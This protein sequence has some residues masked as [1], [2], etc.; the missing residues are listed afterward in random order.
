M[1]YHVVV[2]L[3]LALDGDA[4]LLEQLRRAL[5]LL[6]GL[7]RVFRRGNVRLRHLN[8]SRIK[9]RAR[10]TTPDRKPKLNLLGRRLAAEG[11]FFLPGKLAE[12]CFARGVGFSF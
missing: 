12:L 1:R 10:K 9:Q 3:E 2:G 7:E 11:L 4:L 5:R 8:R 6:L